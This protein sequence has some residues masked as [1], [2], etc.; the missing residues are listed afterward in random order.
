MSKHCA[1]DRSQER[2]PVSNCHC[3]I[4]ATIMPVHGV[5]LPRFIDRLDVS[6]SCVLT[7]IDHRKSR[8]EAMF[9]DLLQ[10][11]ILDS[12]FRSVM[13]IAVCGSS[14]FGS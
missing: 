2:S 7:F 9:I 1:C 3:G 8:S 13:Q 10:L 4:G 6:Q 14:T 12:S 11:K 5:Y